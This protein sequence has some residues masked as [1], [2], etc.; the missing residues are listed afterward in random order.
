MPIEVGDLRTESFIDIWKN[1]GVMQSLRERHDLKGHCGACSYRNIC[2]GCRARA[3]AYFN[4]IKAPDIG[5]INNCQ[6]YY[7]TYYDTLKQTGKEISCQAY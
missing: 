5:C 1:S 3:Y 6:F 4:D 7:D 2:G